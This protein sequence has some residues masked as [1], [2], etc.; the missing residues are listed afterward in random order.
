MLS[1]SRGRGR[2]R[3]TEEDEDV[4][5]VKTKMGH[6]DKEMPSRPGT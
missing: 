4:Q 2:E 5:K 6:I 3:L 1:F